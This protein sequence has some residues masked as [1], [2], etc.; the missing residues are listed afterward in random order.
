MWRDYKRGGGGLGRFNEKGLIFCT[1]CFNFGDGANMPWPLPLCM[2]QHT[3]G[4]T[5]G[6]MVHESGFICFFDRDRA[7]E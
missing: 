6:G 2:A 5:M 3:T 4:L 7:L 1:T